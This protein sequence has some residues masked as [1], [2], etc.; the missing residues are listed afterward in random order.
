MFQSLS[1]ERQKHLS[2]ALLALLIL[3]SLFVL[4]RAINEFKRG[5]VLAYEGETLATI[6]V[7][8]EGEAV[9][10]PDI[11]TFTFAV[12]ET[13]D[14][15]EDAQAQ[16]TED[17]NAIIAFLKDEGIAERDIKTT[18]YNVHPRYDY[19]NVQCISDPCPD[20]RVLVGYEVSQG[21]EVT[22]RDLDETGALLSGVGTRGAT[23]VS[24]LNFTFDDDT[25]VQREARQEAIA[26]AKEKAREL[27]RD[28]D[29]RLVRIIDF[30]E[31]R[32]GYPPVPYRMEASEDM[33]M[34]S[35]AQAPDV[36]RGE[37]KIFSNVTITYAIK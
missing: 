13:A 17:T 24:G 26:A 32:N 23:N 33:A 14:A 29:V 21:V 11:G 35:S 8:G 10:V 20:N 18:Y 30:S 19:R 36:P 6:S 25:E 9:A 28:L 31:S 34:G 3:L 7:S 2:T 37:N 12:S 4:A 15:V 5:D 27:A 16:V 22:V 1:A